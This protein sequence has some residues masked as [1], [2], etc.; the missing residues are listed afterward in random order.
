M[1]IQERISEIKQKVAPIQGWVFDEAGAK[2]YE[3]VRFH[4]PNGTVVEL[5][6][7][8]GRSTVWLAHAVM[9]RGDGV[10]Y[11]VDT[12][13]GTAT[14]EGHQQLLSGYKENQLF[15]EFRR[16]LTNAGVYPGVIA[17]QGDTV[18]VSN[19]FPKNLPIGLLF[20][21]ACHDYPAV[22]EDFERWSPMVAEG[23]Y[24]VFDDVPSWEGPTRFVAEL[25]PSYKIRSI[26]HNQCIVKK[27]K[28]S[29]IRIADIL[30]HLYQKEGPAFVAEA[31]RELLNREP[32]EQGLLGHVQLLAG[33]VGKQGIVSGIVQSAEAA[34]L[35][36]RGG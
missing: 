4:T 13:K 22:K 3:L 32:E 9:D 28:E 12:W 23:G 33:G 1:T 8:K 21:D 24:I 20:I 6:S 11:A 7:W 2:L 19:R 26:Q 14:E 36:H 17:I 34:Q 25:P 15:E 29:D 5:G 31:Y 27:M 30:Q 16:N 35:Y 10:V 18:E